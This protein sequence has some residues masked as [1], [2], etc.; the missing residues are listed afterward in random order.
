MILIHIA[1]RDKTSGKDQLQVFNLELRQKMKSC[2]MADQVVFWKWVTP[3]LLA[4]V[5]AKAVYHWSMEDTCMLF[6]FD[7]LFRLLILFYRASE[8]AQ[9]FLRHES[10]ASA[11]IISYRVDPTNKWAVVVG[12]A[13]TVCRLSYCMEWRFLTCDDVAR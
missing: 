5:T 7:L 1:A 6:P 12:I 4:L 8:P 9:M 11:Q 2:V 3:T 13:R 10:L